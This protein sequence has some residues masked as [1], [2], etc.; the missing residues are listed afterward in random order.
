MEKGQFQQSRGVMYAYEW[1]V[2]PYGKKFYLDFMALKQW[3]IQTCLSI[4]YQCYSFVDAVVFCICNVS[5]L[6]NWQSNTFFTP[7]HISNV[8]CYFRRISFFCH[9]VWLLEWYLC[10]SC[11]SD[12]SSGTHRLGAYVNSFSLF[13]LKVEEMEQREH[14]MA[15]PGLMHFTEK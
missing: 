13:L 5:L 6:V 4:I 11:F 2:L 15:M 7:M 3:M 10:S 1:P 8:S 9:S 14:E 12:F